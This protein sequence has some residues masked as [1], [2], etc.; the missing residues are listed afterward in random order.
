[1]PLPLKALQYGQL[2]F[3]TAGSAVSKSS[4]EVRKAEFYDADG[5]KK[6]GFYK[7]LGPDYPCLL[8]KISVAYSVLMRMSSGTQVAADRLVLDD[9]SGEVLGTLSYALPDY[10]PML[11]S[12]ESLPIDLQQKELRCPSEETLVGYNFTEMLVAEYRSG[13]NDAHPGNM[14]IA[15]KEEGKV[16]SPFVPVIIDHDMRGYKLTSIIK[17]R[18]FT[19]GITEDS[20]ESIVMDPSDFNN[21][22]IINGRTHWPANTMPGN[23]YMPKRY[24]AYAQFQGLAKNP[25]LQTEK[26]PVSFQDQLFHAL[27]KQLVL[28]SPGILKPWLIDYFGDIPLDFMTL[29]V[30]KRGA[31]CKAYPQL[32]NNQT[33]AKP[34]VDFIMPYFKQEYNEFYLASAFYPG[35]EKNASGTPVISMNQYLQNKPSAFRDI[36]QWATEQNTQMEQAWNNFDQKKYHED[37]KRYE[38]KRQEYQQVTLQHGKDSAEST[39]CMNELQ[40]CIPAKPGWYCIAPKHRFDI[41]KLQQRY[42]QIWRDSHILLI[43]EIIFATQILANKKPVTTSLC[44]STQSA[45]KAI[46]SAI[47]EAWQL[48]ETSSTKGDKSCSLNSKAGHN[49][50]LEAFH[51]DLH[52][53]A[54]AYYK[55]KRNDLDIESNL[56]F[57]DLATKL[58]RDYET[59]VYKTLSSSLASEF[60]KIVKN[61]VQCYGRLNFPRHLN[62]D[63][64]ELSIKDKYDY[65]AVLQRKHTEPDV[66]TAALKT[67]FNWAKK[68]DRETLDGAILEIIQM[69]YEPSYINLT[70]NRLRSNEVTQ[71]LKN[72]EE[73]SGDNKL[74]YILSCGGTESTSLNTLLVKHLMPIVL[75]DTIAVIDVNLM[76]VSQAFERNEFK[77][78][79]YTEHAV[80]YAK[81]DLRF[82]HLYSKASLERFNNI[83]YRWVSLVKPQ[84]FKD[85][86]F[87]VLG[88]YEPYTLN[89]LSKKIRGPEVRQYFNSNNSNQL[90]LAYIFSGGDIQKNSLNTLLFNK[91]LEVMTQSISSSSEARKDIDFLWILDIDFKNMHTFNHFLGSLQAC[92]KN[93]SNSVNSIPSTEE[94]MPSYK[95]G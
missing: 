10:K 13:N 81:R 18:R 89:L 84:A 29:D 17:G 92:A 49:P 8:A 22:P 47:T 6:T 2:K 61:L 75:R 63:D 76:S 72:S 60:A 19:S 59:T 90:I 7:P 1:M 41:T 27:L 9:I 5:E 70:A 30:D 11:C 55:T 28:F 24:M 69:Y 36:L 15:R 43:K 48:I 38:A 4:H 57:I 42:H 40:S 52:T 71:Y 37:S 62:E 3:E 53:Y 50:A 54:E 91:I 67:L 83:L 33:N 93:K 86:V 34:F 85:M 25:V 66:M 58:I 46:P 51:N 31:L 87:K 80:N 88:H 64:V 16:D 94:S 12:G 78:A 20:P 73:A 45:T 65:S 95:Y 68:I 44:L 82:T 26:G 74:A 21:F 14:G 35:C 77:D 39:K 56:T 79:L 32:F 23:L